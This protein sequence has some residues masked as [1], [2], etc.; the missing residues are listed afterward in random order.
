MADLFGASNTAFSGNPEAYGGPPGSG[1]AGKTCKDCV[2]AE[3]WGA[4]RTYWKCALVK[5][6]SGPGTDIR[7]RT[8]ACNR[9]EPEPQ[10][11]QCT[12]MEKP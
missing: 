2:H 12:N 11:S 3:G 4:N 8:P 10:S 6:T 1:P 5:H 9:F 7:L